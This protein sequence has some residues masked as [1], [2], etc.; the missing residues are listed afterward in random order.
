MHSYNFIPTFQDIWKARYNL[1]INDLP[2]IQNILKDEIE[3]CISF[4]NEI[5]KTN[6]CP[7]KIF[8]FYAIIPPDVIIEDREAYYETNIPLT[9]EYI[10]SIELSNNFKYMLQNQEEGK[11]EC[12]FTTMDLERLVIAFQKK[13]NSPRENHTKKIR[14]FF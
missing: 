6:D 13:F 3:K 4:P 5:S 14:T 1:S 2:I 9:Q 12:K 10:E 11:L 7:E 8:P